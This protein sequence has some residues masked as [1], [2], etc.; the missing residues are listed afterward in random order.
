MSIPEAAAEAS[1]RQRPPQRRSWARTMEPGVG[2]ASR[3]E[4]AWARGGAEPGVLPPSEPGV[5]ARNPA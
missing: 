4:P 3:R 1:P 2:L 5:S